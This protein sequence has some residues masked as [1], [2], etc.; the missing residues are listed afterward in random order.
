MGCCFAVVVTVAGRPG[1]SWSGSGIVPCLSVLFQD[2]LKPSGNSFVKGWKVAKKC[3]SRAV[4]RCSGIL[5]PV[6]ARRATNVLLAVHGRLCNPG[7]PFDEA[8]ARRSG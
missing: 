1:Y 5:A 8:A 4:G 2:W 6:G 3:R 7:A